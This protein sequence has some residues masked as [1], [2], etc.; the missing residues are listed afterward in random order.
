MTATEKTYSP[1]DAEQAFESAR[2]LLVPLF[3]TL[4][5]RGVMVAAVAMWPDGTVMNG[6]F[7]GTGLMHRDALLEASDALRDWHAGM[8]TSGD[9]WTSAEH[10]SGVEALL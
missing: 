1:E 6:E 8:V 7:V 3:N 2:Q 4:R 10:T 5:E 9:E